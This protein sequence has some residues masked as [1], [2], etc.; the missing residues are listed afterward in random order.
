[1]QG[2]ANQFFLSFLSHRI[3]SFNNYSSSLVG[4]EISVPHDSSFGPLLFLFYINDLPNSDQSTPLLF[5]DDTC[6]LISKST[7]KKL[8]NELNKDIT[9]I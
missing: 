1:M 6:L 2:A 8:Q 7:P 3:V 9:S 5:A 4:I